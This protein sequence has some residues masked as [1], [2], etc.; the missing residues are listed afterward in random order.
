[1]AAPCR[2]G[3]R[4]WLAP[5]CLGSSHFSGV[6]LPIDPQSPG[7]SL[8]LPVRGDLEQARLSCRSPSG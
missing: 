8:M 2:M 6:Y 4:W 7:T 3:H 5:Q 1:M